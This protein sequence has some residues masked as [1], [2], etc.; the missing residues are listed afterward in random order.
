MTR[1][2]VVD[3]KELTVKHL[4][5]EYR[6]ITRLP[7]NLQT[8]LNRKTSPFSLKEIPSEYVLGKGH[9]KF[10]F[11]K[12]LFLKKRF[13]SLV[14]EMLQRGYNPT[15]RDSSIFETEEQFMND[16]TPTDEAIK[17]NRERI[18]DRLK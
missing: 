9:V 13:E 16:Y 8:A 17:I 14:D 18:Q 4:V 12:M 7:K 5:A 10:F 6:E 3:P 1:I 11:D 15:Y 2:N